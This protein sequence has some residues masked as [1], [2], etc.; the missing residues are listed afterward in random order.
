MGESVDY[1]AKVETVL[2]GAFILMH[3]TDRATPPQYQAEI[4]VG[5]SETRGDLVAHWIDSTGADGARVVGSGKFVADG[6]ELFFP[7][8]GRALRDHFLFHGEGVFD[9]E[10]DASR[11][12]EGWDEFAR[13]RFTM[14][15]C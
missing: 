1:C 3:L 2:A 12:G 8:E 14:E 11:D 15:S 5:A 9:L 10:V 6:F 13:H 4:Y 7:Y